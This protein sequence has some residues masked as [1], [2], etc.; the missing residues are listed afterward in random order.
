MNGM[1]RL[2]IAA[3]LMVIAL[4]TLIPVIGASARQRH[5]EYRTENGK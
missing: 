2:A 1:N 3:I 5:G 4:V